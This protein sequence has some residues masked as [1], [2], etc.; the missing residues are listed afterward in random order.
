MYNNKKTTMEKETLIN[1]GEG[2]EEREHSC[3]VGG[4]VN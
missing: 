1:A 2:V 4:N 3:T